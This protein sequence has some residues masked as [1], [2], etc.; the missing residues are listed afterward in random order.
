MVRIKVD[1]LICYLATDTAQV[2]VL[3]EVLILWSRK[4]VF[5]CGSPDIFRITRW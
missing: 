4:I 1:K 5:L 3:L 2:R